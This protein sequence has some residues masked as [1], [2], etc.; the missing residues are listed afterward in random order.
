M[1]LLAQSVAQALGLGLQ[2]FFEPRQLAQ[3]DDQRILGR[4]PAE[5]RQIRQQCGR[6]GQGI[7][8]IIF[9]AGHRVPV[10]KAGVPGTLPSPNPAPGGNTPDE[11]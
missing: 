5:G 7:A 6:Q 9:G 4:Q 11:A 1:Q 2:V 3:F 8:P 10:A